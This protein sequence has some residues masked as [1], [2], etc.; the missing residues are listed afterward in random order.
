MVDIPKD[1]QFQK[2]K[3]KSS[4]EVVVETYKP[5][6]KAELTNIEKAGDDCKS[7]KPI[8]YSG[9]GVINAGIR[10]SDALTDLHV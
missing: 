7:K 3:Y 10:A 8:I 4:K 9:G 1:V 6:V 2:G 5:K